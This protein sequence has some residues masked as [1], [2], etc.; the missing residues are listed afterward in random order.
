[1]NSVPVVHALP[2]LCELFLSEIGVCAFVLVV[3]QQ[4]ASSSIAAS[5]RDQKSLLLLHSRL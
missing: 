2:C 5:D 1:M 3:P 4:D